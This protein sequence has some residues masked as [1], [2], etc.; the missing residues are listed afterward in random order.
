MKIRLAAISLDNLPQA[1][2][3]IDTLRNAVNAGDMNSIDTATDKLLALTN[4]EHSVN[5]SEEEWKKFLAEIRTKNPA[6]QSDYL[7]PGE[8]CSQIFSNITS[9]MMVLQLP[10]D[11]K[12]EDDV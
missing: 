12:G 8:V 6:F 3:L 10:F 7:I 11:E 9:K 5:L 1:H 2:P 4:M